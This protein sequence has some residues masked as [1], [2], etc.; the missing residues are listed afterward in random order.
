VGVRVCVCWVVMRGGGVRVFA[1]ACG[2]GVHVL[3]RVFGCA[4]VRARVC[5]VFGSGCYP[6]PLLGLHAPPLSAP[7]PYFCTLSRSHRRYFFNVATMGASFASVRSGLSERSQWVWCAVTGLCLG[8]CLS[9]KLTALGLLATVGV[10][11]LLCLIASSKDLETV[12]RRG[13]PRAGIIL[14]ITA[15]I[16][17]GLWTVHVK[18]LPCVWQ[19]LHDH[20][21]S[22]P[23]PPSLPTTATHPPY[24]PPRLRP[25]CAPCTL[26]HAG[27]RSISPGAL[28]ITSLVAAVA[29]GRYS[30]QGDGFMNT[31]YQATLVEKTFP[32]KPQ[33][34]NHANA[35]YDCGFYGITE[36]QC[37]DKKCC[38]DPTSPKV[39]GG[40]CPCVAQTHTHTT[41][42][43]PHVGDASCSL[44]RTLAWPVFP[45]AR[46]RPQV[47]APTI[48]KSKCTLN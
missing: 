5:G 38:W 14:S 35:I 42:R 26:P 28:S 21:P 30:G 1:G 8:C 18:I 4:C 2:W 39:C 16:F 47:P 10:H 46:P 15:F 9:V 29:C 40:I 20:P 44:S 33:C 48:L 43:V 31:E 11:Q 23:L 36:Q 13:L 3:V 27:W 12:L 45:H 6:A 37:L 34:P 7:H 32:H 25:N 22:L 24:H 41:P 17:F 19:A